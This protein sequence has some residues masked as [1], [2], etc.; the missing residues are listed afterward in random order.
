MVAIGKT[1]YPARLIRQQDRAIIKTRDAGQRHRLQVSR[2]FQV[3]PRSRDSKALPRSPNAKIEW[4]SVAA[5]PKI[6]S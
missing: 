2:R 3:S 6:V 1:Q 5:R 4:L